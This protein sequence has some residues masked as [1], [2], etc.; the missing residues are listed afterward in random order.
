MR[1]AALGN[2][3]C[4][5]VADGAA[6][7]NGPALVCSGSPGG[8]PG[9]GGGTCQQF[10]RMNYNHKVEGRAYSTGSYWAPDYFANGSNDPMAG[11]T[12]GTTTLHSTDGSTWRVGACP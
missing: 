6:S 8:D 1:E 4:E 5:W 10:S 2:G 9:G 12:Y 7:C 3:Q 11:S